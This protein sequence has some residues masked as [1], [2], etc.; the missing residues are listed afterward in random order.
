VAS[1]V[2]LEP[3]QFA[4]L[5]NEV[6]RDCGPL[7]L[8]VRLETV[9]SWELSHTQLSVPVTQQKDDGGNLATIGW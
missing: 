7:A 9:R 5:H 6:C 2:V 1:A 4:A 8:I 3:V